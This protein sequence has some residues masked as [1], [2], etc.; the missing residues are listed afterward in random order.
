[1]QSAMLSHSF[2]VE[3]PELSEA[4]HNLKM[5]DRHF[6]HVLEQYDAVDLK[7]M[8]DEEKIE[9][10]NDD[11]LHELKL[12]RLKLKDELYQMATQA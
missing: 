9:P 6:N 3:F 2:L 4:I 5:N 8:R 1:M 11:T 10:I 12:Q 7:I